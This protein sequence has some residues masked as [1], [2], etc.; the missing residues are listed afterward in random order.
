METPEAGPWESFKERA[1]HIAGKFGDTLS[2]TLSIKL[3]EKM[4]DK[5]IKML[6]FNRSH[7]EGQP[8]VDTN[9]NPDYN[10]AGFIPNVSKFSTTRRRTNIIFLLAF[11]AYICLGIPVVY[12]SAKMPEISSSLKG[13][14]VILEDNS[15]N[16]ISNLIPDIDQDSVYSFN[17]LMTVLHEKWEEYSGK[18]IIVVPPGKQKLRLILPD[19]TIVIMDS[20]S[21]LEF[22]MPFGY[23]DRDVTLRGQA[24]FIVKPYNALGFKVAANMVCVNASNA[25][26]NIYSY[27]ELEEFKISVVADTAWVSSQKITDPI[28]DGKLCAEEEAI[29]DSESQFLEKKGC[30]KNV[31]RS[32]IETGE[33]FFYKTS[34]KDLCKVI[35]RLYQVTVVIDGDKMKGQYYTGS[36]NES[37]SLNELLNK[38]RQTDKIIHSYGRNNEVHVRIN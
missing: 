29:F 10:P 25:E 28:R 24:Y 13:A 23:K 16:P 34:Y 2:N 12:L 35:E 11:V 1:S 32:W 36:F 8:A 21:S 18:V 17:N 20:S 14:C 9:V 4:A 3:G 22:K 27:P 6:S 31:V 30:I 19:G 15:I 26:F 33:Y 5:I 37:I 38:L 7:L